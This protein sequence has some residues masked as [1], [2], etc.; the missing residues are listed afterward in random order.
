MYIYS[1]YFVYLINSSKRLNRYHVKTG[2]W[3]KQVKT[4]TVQLGL[5][6]VIR[7]TVNGYIGLGPGLGL[8]S[9]F[10]CPGSDV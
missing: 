2:I 7:V 8:G 6:L 5:G 4:G 10:G 1:I 3:S 9:R